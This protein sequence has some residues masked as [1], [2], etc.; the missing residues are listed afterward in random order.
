MKN[1]KNK[2]K[3]DTAQLDLFTPNK[4]T[5]PTPSN[6]GKADEPQSKIVSMADFRHQQEIKK[7]Y[8]VANQVT[9]HLDK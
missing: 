1:S 6:P 5:A 3:N 4:P 7:F 8:E 9:S 2:D